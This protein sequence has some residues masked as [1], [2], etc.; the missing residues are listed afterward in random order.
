MIDIAGF[1]VDTEFYEA[2]GKASGVIQLQG[3]GAKR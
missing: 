3:A 1:I 2:T